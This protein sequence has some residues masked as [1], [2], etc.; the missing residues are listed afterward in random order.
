MIEKLRNDCLERMKT[1]RNAPMQK[2]TDCNENNLLIAK[3]KLY[4]LDNENE[5]KSF[6]SKFVIQEGP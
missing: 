5:E 2:T 4:C 3:T 1:E 6:L